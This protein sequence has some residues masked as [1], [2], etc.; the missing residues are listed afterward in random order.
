MFCGLQHFFS[1]CAALQEN[2]DRAGGRHD[3]PGGNGQE[4]AEEHRFDGEFEMIFL[5]EEISGELADRS[6][7]GRCFGSFPFEN[8]SFNRDYAHDEA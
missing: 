8:V 1:A 5:R 2:A 7:T 4:R 6:M 3:R